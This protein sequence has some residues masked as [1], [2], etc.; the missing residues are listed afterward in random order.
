M[1]RNF[2]Y[3]AVLTIIAWLL[4]WIYAPEDEPSGQAVA[5]RYLLPGIAKKINQANRVEIV[6]AGNNTVATLL[7][8]GQ[9]WKFEQMGGYHANWVKLQSLLAGLA[10]ARIV[11]AKTDKAEYY[12]RLG[13]EDIVAEDA[14]GVLVRISIA[15]E[16][17]GILIG[18]RATSRQ[19]QYVRL[20]NT[21]ASALVDRLLDVSSE[22]LDWADSEIIDI[23]AAEVAEVEI[24]HPQGERLLVTRISADQTDFDLVAL[25]QD[26]QIKSS[27]AVNSLASVLSMLNMETVRT[28]SGID[29]SRA[30][31][32]RLLMFSGVEIMA[33]M[34]AVDD[35]YLLRLHADYP[36]AAVVSPPVN[37][38]T[39]NTEQP[40]IDRQVAIDVEK[41]V[42][43][44]NKK[45]AG[46]VYGIS[47]YKF[48]AMVKLPED[49]LD[50]L[51]S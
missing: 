48:D 37:T 47:K 8:T 33:D 49:L 41:S 1:K 11:E 23:S 5:D 45:V 36:A 40:D 28:D 51:E 20:Q 24:I 4:L 27:W 13:V 22:P 31:K 34:L 15:D 10:Q 46:W 16:T 17:T 18:H 50:P 39:D 9:G 21:A 14:R 3:L 29:W 43:D 42:D 19:G 26:R 30:I 6:S 35:A 12:T 44:I 32:M 2:L 7:K 25:P 38:G